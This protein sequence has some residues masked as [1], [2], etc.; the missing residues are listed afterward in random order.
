MKKNRRQFLRNVALGIIG[1]SVLPVIAKT[2]VNSSRLNQETCNPLTED[3]YGE[4]PFY[5]E[6]PPEI[7]NGILASVSEVGQ[8]V[9][10]SGIVKDLSCL[11]VIPNT[12][13][14]IWHANNS[15]SYS[16]GSDYTLRGKT[17]TN[18]LGFYSIETILPGKY[19]NGSRLRPSHFH[20]KVSPPGFPTFT[21]QTYFEGDEQIPADPAASEDSGQYDATNRILPFTENAEGTIEVVWDIVIDGDGVLG[22]DNLHLTRGMIYSV[23]PNPFEGEITINYGVF[24]TA[25]IKI[26]I[27]NLQGALVAKIN[28]NQLSPEK[29]TAIWKPEQ[30]LSAGIYFCA[31]KVND[32]QVHYKK[33][34]KR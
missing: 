2:R 29:Y 17:N 7:Q 14:D 8:R 27:Y 26:E 32:I 33:I 25:N 1:T 15:G 13:I 21:T 20:F 9:V 5:T 18:N 4:G 12:E 22:V 6:N 28:K 30:K 10:I 34:I 23:S 31:L 16:S 19:L 24:K 11:E 3:F